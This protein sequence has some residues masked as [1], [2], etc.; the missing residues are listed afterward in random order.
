MIPAPGLRPGEPR[1]AD[2][3]W[4]QW[5]SVLPA[6]TAAM[7]GGLIGCDT[8]S[9]AGGAPTAG[10]MVTI[11]DSADVEIVENHAPEWP[12]DQFWT[13]DPEPR[14]VLGGSDGAGV[15]EAG[16]QRDDLDGRIWVVKG[17]ARL[18]DGRIAVL[19]QGNDQ[20]FIFEPSGA[21]SRT[22]GGRG[23]GPGEFASP[24]RL[25]YLPPDTLAVWDHW[26]GPVTY[27]DT[28]GAVLDRR[29]IDLGRVLAAVPEATVE[30]ATFPLPDGSFVVT[31]RHRDPDLVRPPEGTL[32]R[33]P[34]VEYV[35]VDLDTYVA[36]SLGIWDGEEK[37]AVPDEVRALYPMLASG[38]EHGLVPL[39]G[40]LMSQ[41]TAAGRPPAIYVTNGDR[42]EIRQFALDGTL[43]RI[44]RRTT[45]PVV[46]T[47][48]ANRAWRDYAMAMSGGEYGVE[49]WPEREHYPFIAGIMVDAAGYL[50]VREWSESESGMPDQWSVFD[51]NG[52]WLGVVAGFP[53]IP[54]VCHGGPEVGPCWIDRDWLVI[55]TADDLGRE[56]IEG[57]RIHRDGWEL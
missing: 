9:S 1:R 23:E 46:A 45:S 33:Y 26:M 8:G 3:P 47:E 28:A 19:S 50:W 24:E 51:P 31:I 52:R 30:S 43:L 34:P 56:R 32:V 40:E 57:Y 7:I 49:A 11:R 44:I 38:Y 27:F 53:D 15:G 29:L 54:S 22:I 20:L 55:L 13:L 16:G 25:Q 37:W 17:L 14:F 2:R 10:P 42:N 5:S 36:R 48:R 21:L 39:A 35:R 4:F 18:V 6:A 12:L 41:L